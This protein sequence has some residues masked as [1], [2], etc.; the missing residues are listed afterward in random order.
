M[1]AC[2]FRPSSRAFSSRHHQHR[3]GAV[4]ERAGVA[5]R[6]G[7]VRLEGRL[8]LRE[9]LHRRAGAR[10]VVLGDDRLGDVDLVALL[11]GVVC[12]GT[13]TGTIS[14]VEVAGL[15][16]RD[17]ALL[18]DRGPLVLRLARDALAL[19]DVLGRQ[20]HR[21]V[22]VVERALGAVELRVELGTARRRRAR[23]TASTPAA[24]YVSPSPALIAWKAMRIVCSEEAQKRLTVVPG[25]PIGEPGEQRARCGRRCSPARPRRRPRPSSRR[26]SSEE[27]SCGLRSS[28]ALSGIAARSSARTSFSEPLTARPIGVRIASTMT[29]SDMW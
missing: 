22:D 21:D 2:G 5:G 23:E 12:S 29:A 9:L 7:A 24:M 8:Q 18:R 1:R 20:A 10:A 25:T 28:S 13:T 15:L 4:V 6:D 11:V 3:G 27:S 16:R 17:R 19:G 26:R 14:A